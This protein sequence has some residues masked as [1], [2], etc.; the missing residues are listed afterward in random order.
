MREVILVLFKPG[1]ACHLLVRLLLFC[2]LKAHS[3]NPEKTQKRKNTKQSKKSKKRKFRT[4]WPWVDLFYMIVLFVLFVFFFFFRFWGFGDCVF[5]LQKKKQYCLSFGLE[6]DSLN[7]I[8]CRAQMPRKSTT[9]LHNK[10][11][12]KNVIDFYKL[13]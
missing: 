10:C 1:H 5:R 4:R 8:R 12:A 2:I 7:K 3:P 11:N 9:R 13:Y 6:Q